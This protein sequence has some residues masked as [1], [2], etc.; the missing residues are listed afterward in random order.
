[1]ESSNSKYMIITVDREVP[2][3]YDRCCTLAPRRPPPGIDYT[4]NDLRARLVFL[5]RLEQPT[6]PRLARF[7]AD[8]R[9]AT[10]GAFRS[11]GRRRREWQE[12]LREYDRTAT[13]RWARYVP[14]EE[15]QTLRDNMLLLKRLEYRDRY[16][17]LSEPAHAAALGVDL[18]RPGMESLRRFW[19]RQILVDKYWAQERGLID[20]KLCRAAADLGLDVLQVLAAATLFVLNGSS[21][22]LSVD[23]LLAGGNYHLMRAFIVR[24]ALEVRSVLASSMMEYIDSIETLLEYMKEVF[25]MPCPQE[26]EPTPN[27]LTPLAY[28]TTAQLQKDAGT[29]TTAEFQMWAGLNA[30]GVPRRIWRA[31]VDYDR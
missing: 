27:Y 22:R 21:Q 2:E 1:M 24:D 31:R 7:I 16:T 19:A 28:E 29:G 14:N 25:W 6:F 15:M 5:R 12:T 3:G 9:S 30:R 13:R 26:L 10:K 11:T 8:Y 4:H 17:D 18:T 20:V 23:R